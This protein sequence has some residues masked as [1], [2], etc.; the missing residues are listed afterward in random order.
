MINGVALT[1]FITGAI[2]DANRRIIPVFS[3]T[4]FPRFILFLQAMRVNNMLIK[5]PT[6]EADPHLLFVSRCLKREFLLCNLLSFVFQQ[7]DGL[8]KSRFGL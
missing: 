8:R 5:G 2:E 6:K 3:S 7:I 4:V 1:I